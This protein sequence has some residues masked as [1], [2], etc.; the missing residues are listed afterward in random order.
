[1]NK[2]S[3]LKKALT[4]LFRSGADARHSESEMLKLLDGI[5][6]L[7]LLQSV[8]ND[9][10]TVYQYLA[11]GRA[12]GDFE[13]YGPELLTQKATLLY[14]DTTDRADESVSCA[15][16]LE[17]WLLPDMTFAVISC[18]SVS[19]RNGTYLTE[20]RTY[21]G[22]DW[23]ETGMQIDFPALAEKLRKWSEAVNENEPPMFEV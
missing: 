20:Y 10:D 1:M 6:C 8:H 11:F 7:T 16:T 5:N 2:V 13:Y 9:A 3:D 14:E 15:R 12:S 17:L 18:F 19:V 22:R 23:R 21:K 4:L